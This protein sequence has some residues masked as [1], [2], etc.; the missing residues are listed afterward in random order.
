MTVAPAEETNPMNGVFRRL[1]LALQAGADGASDGRLLE[2]F[3]A[4]RDEAAFAALV[5]RHGPMVLGVCRR[6]LRHQQDAED[7][8]QAA[9]VVL[10][11]RAASVRAETLGNWLYGVAYRTAIKAKVMSAKRRSREQEAGRMP[12]PEMSPDEPW[13]EVLPLL[14]RELSRLPDKYRSPVVLCELQGK[15]RKDA[16]GQLG[17][18][19][20]T[21]SS[22][23]NRARAL[24]ARRLSRHG[25]AATAGALGL[26]LAA[27]APARVPARLLVSTVTAATGPTPADVAA[28]TEGVLKVMLLERLRLVTAIALTLALVGLSVAAAC[29]APGGAGGGEG[30]AGA[31][32]IPGGA[33][34]QR[35]GGGDGAGVA[36]PDSPMPTPAAVSLDENGRVLVRMRG[37]F[38]GMGGMMGMPGG[39]GGMMP[40][41][42]GKG[43]GIIGPGPGGV[44]P[45]GGAG[46]GGPGG[47]GRGGAIAPPGQA[48][49]PL[50]G[51]GVAPPGQ[52]P[53]G[54]PGGAG[55][56]GQ[57]GRAGGF[58]GGGFGG[59]GMGAFPAMTHTYPLDKVRAYDGTGKKIAGNALAR[60]LTKEVP[61]L[62]YLQGNGPDPLHLNFLKADTLILVVPGPNGPIGGGGFGGGFPGGPG[63]GAGGF[64]G[65]P[66]APPGGIGGPGG[67]PPGVGPGGFQ[68][69]P[70]GG[71]STPPE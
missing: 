50:P 33:A 53:G 48:P 17:V 38:M 6:V 31:P 3:L 47:F 41:P 59:P 5:R 37:G 32:G 54:L 49:G 19:E 15:S 8:F 39:R 35:G 61:A 18:P 34:P 27:E 57:G 43:G 55:A 64:P 9:F 20:G 70:G 28:L 16:A 14:D 60:R 65:A 23:L 63:G 2:A 44:P 68:R 24:L 13:R 62:V 69:Q 46:A 45:G 52:G 4:R 21:L 56:P 58:G 51:G 22:R 40:G 36:L 7:A 29:Q 1:R 30:Q 42:G 12:R 66:G 26:A 71:E 67:P 25:P 11:R 10:A